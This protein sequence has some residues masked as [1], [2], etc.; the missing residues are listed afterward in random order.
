MAI[1]QALEVE[2]DGFGQSA[3]M[4]RRDFGGRYSQVD[5]SGL[6]GSEDGDGRFKTGEGGNL[7]NS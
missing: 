6:S 2:G 1:E 3:G 5:G 7:D 4:E